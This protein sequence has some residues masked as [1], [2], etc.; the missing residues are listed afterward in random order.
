MKILMTLKCEP[1]YAKSVLRAISVP[2]FEMSGDNG[3][4]SDI[5][6]PGRLVSR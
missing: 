6:K 2:N 5:L 1:R 4:G 3:I